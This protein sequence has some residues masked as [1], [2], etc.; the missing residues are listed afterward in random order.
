MRIQKYQIPAN[1]GEILSGFIERRIYDAYK[2]KD[3]PD[4]RF[5]PE[6]F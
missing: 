4:L 3:N 1:G 6:E 5:Q 2:Y